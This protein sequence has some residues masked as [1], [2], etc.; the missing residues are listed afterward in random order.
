MTS[1]APE[2]S[3]GA[4]RILVA[5]SVVA[6]V[7]ALIAHDRLIPLDTPLFGLFQNAVDA[8]V[9]RAGGLTVLHGTPLYD[10]N[11][12]DDLPFT[13]P[14]FA[15]LIFAPLGLIS[16]ITTK[17]LFWIGNLVLLYVA[18][19]LC[20]RHLGYANDVW[21]TAVSASLAVVFTWLEPVRMTIW[22]GQINLL[23]MVAVL[24]DL[25][26]PEGSR[27]RGVATGLA[28]GTKLTPGLF[29]VYLA[30]TRQW[31]AAATAAVATL[32]T[33]VAGFVVIPADATRYWFT[34]VSEST[35][36]GAPSSGANQSIRGALPRW[37]ETVNPPFA[38][39][40]ACV[41]V[42][43]ATGIAVAVIAHRR[44]HVLLGLTITGL[45][46]PM[47]SPFSW[48]HHWVWFVPLI[49]LTMDMA[50]RRSRVL[51][52]LPLALMA[53]L[54]C[55][56]FT[57]PDGVRAIGTFML[58]PPSFAV[59][60][61]IQSA[62]PLTYLVVVVGAAIALRRSEPREP[63]VST[64]ARDVTSVT[65][66]VGN[67]T[68]STPV[69]TPPDRPSWEKSRPASQRPNSHRDTHSY[70]IVTSGREAT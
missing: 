64:P 55:W 60:V 42:V 41:L 57:Y 58:P 22:F 50:V 38:L 23:L 40:A 20:W 49:V 19:R 52:A 28:A 6:A 14:P 48:G 34:A 8:G 15:A 53:P 66:R 11:L 27:L 70:R 56:Y 65:S 10:G 68:T 32:T 30:A 35:R 16:M 47:V 62:Y 46:A 12:T 9:Y 1:G 69:T 37:L 36:I 51:W 24:W 54:G 13:Y 25:T 4:H 5:V 63:S 67:G 18:V 44:G 59:G 43:G 21:L 3:F 26:R 7:V 33:V 45:T 2:R 17:L 29:V 31:R 61:V 39:W